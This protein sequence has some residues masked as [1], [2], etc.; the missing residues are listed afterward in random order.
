MQQE[1]KARNRIIIRYNMMGVLMNLL[2]SSAKIITGLVVSSHAIFLDG[3]NSLSDVLSAAISI[4]STMFGAKKASVSHP[5]GYGRMEYMSSFLITML[6]MYVGIRSVIESVKS[7]LH[8]RGVPDYNLIAV[9]LMVLSLIC[10]FIYGIVMRRK[11]KLINSTVMVMTGTESFGDSLISLSILGA[12]VFY[13]LSGVNIEYYLCI[14]ISLLILYTGVRV[15]FEAMTKI[16]GTRTDPEVKKGIIRLFLEEKAV[17]NVTNLILHNYG[18][19]VYVGSADIEVDENMRA[20]EISHLTRRLIRSAGSRGITITSIGIS[21]AKLTDPESDR[22]FDMVLKTAMKYPS[23]QR[24]HSFHVDFEE[25]EMSFYIVQRFGSKDPE[26]EYRSFQAD[27]EACFRGFTI[28]ISK[29][30]NA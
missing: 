30:L 24:V 29:A 11:G 10:K 14:A 25:K 23:I 6:I 27:M 22:M 4:L 12:I 5:F 3:I 8:P 26:Q 7:I 9:G 13:R 19:N 18:E 15:L 17:Q 20:A 2:L 1:I 28:D 16:L 21:G